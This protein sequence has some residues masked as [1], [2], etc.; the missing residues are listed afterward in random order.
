MMNIFLKYRII[1]NF[2]RM[3]VKERPYK[4]LQ[5]NC[6]NGTMGKANV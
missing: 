1:L 6:S 4:L 5:I 3:W 2:E